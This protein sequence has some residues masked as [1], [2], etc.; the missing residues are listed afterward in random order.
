M[1]AD[2]E[3][4]VRRFEA[5]NAFG[6]NALLTNQRRNATIAADSNYVKCLSLDRKTFIRL[7]A[8]RE[9]PLFWHR[10]SLKTKWSSL[11]LSHLGKTG[12]VA[13][14]DSAANEISVKFPDNQRVIFPAGALGLAIETT[15]DDDDN[16]D[17]DDDKVARAQEDPLEPPLV[18]S[19]RRFPVDRPTNSDSRILGLVEDWIL[20]DSTALEGRDVSVLQ[21]EE[22][23]RYYFKNQQDEAAHIDERA[24]SVAF[25][26]FSVVYVLTLYKFYFMAVL[27]G[28]IITLNSISSTRSFHQK[29][30][31]LL[32]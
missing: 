32:H 27:A 20:R 4:V 9:V 8:R 13:L 16:D 11:H 15:F 30:K 2:T 17:D 7:T 21:C 29:I 24:L 1:E 3:K 6:E 14:V 19:S 18:S 22:S 10:S 28:L 5:P 12:T 26:M 23:A 25:G 31:H